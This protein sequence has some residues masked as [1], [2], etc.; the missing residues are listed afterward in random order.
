MGTPN[1]LAENTTIVNNIAVAMRRWSRRGGRSTSRSATCSRTGATPSAIPVPGGEGFEGSVSIVGCC[2][3]SNTFAPQGDVGDRVDGRSFRTVGY[4]VTYGNSFVMTL[5]FGPDGPH[6][7]AIL[8][9]GQPDDPASPDFTAQMELFSGGKFRPILF[10]P[11]DV[12]AGAVGEVTTITGETRMTDALEERA[13]RLGVVT[14]WVTVHGDTVRVDPSI[15]EGAIAALGEDHDPAAHTLDVV[16]A[17]DGEVSGLDPGLT[18]H[19]ATGALLG[20]DRPFPLGYHE[21]RDADR[22]VGTVISA[23]RHAPAAAPGQWGVFLP[24]YSLRT[25]RTAGIATYGELTGLFD[26]L[27]DHGGE[28]LLTLPLLPTY[29]D[30]PADWSPYSPVTR[31]MWS[32][33]YVDLD[34]AG[35]PH[36]TTPPPQPVGGLLD[37]PAIHTHH[38][39]R[40]DVVAERLATHPAL[41][42][43]VAEHPLAETYARFR[44]TQA[45]LGRDFRRWGRTGTPRSPPPTH[46]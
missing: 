31:R 46:R 16:V 13:S 10:T 26:W 43:W 6:A 37:Y 41:A 11:E 1:T 15:V 35:A 44:G 14:S 32:E 12:A 29:L 7:E 4:P 40:L 42:R 27:H 18:V 25:H 21:L 45:A 3:G 24:L 34:A 19:D 8:T 28:V 2:S 36:A 39:E 23:P 22:L 5:E 17:W 9:Y 30:D 33:L 20:R 38:T